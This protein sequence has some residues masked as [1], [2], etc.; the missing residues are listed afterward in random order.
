MSDIAIGKLSLGCKKDFEPLFDSF[1]EMKSLFGIAR[2]VLAGGLDLLDCERIFSMYQEL[3]YEGTC[4][5]SISGFTWCAA[6]LF[7]VSLMGMIMITLRSSVQNTEYLESDGGNDEK[8]LNESES[9]GKLSTDVGTTDEDALGSSSE[10]EKATTEEG[11]DE[12]AVCVD[13]EDAPVTAEEGLVAAEDNVY[14]LNK[15]DDRMEDFSEAACESTAD[16]TR[17]AP[18]ANTAGQTKVMD[19]SC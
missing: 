4:T 1:R 2:E 8:D 6:C 15:D 10:G 14:A 18:A 11:N 17:R 12:E 7:I 3:V 9:D 13:E 5:Y 16:H 19:L